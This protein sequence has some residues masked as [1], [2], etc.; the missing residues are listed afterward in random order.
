MDDLRRSAIPLRKV[1]VLE[2][3]DH[4]QRG[5]ALPV[6]RQ[7]AQLVALAVSDAGYIDPLAVVSGE[8]FQRKGAALFAQIVHDDPR[9]LALVI[10]VAAIGCDP[11]QR[12]GEVGIAEHL[13]RFGC[14][15][16]GEPGR[17]GIFEVEI[18]PFE[19]RFVSGQ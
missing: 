3:V 9:G 19:A 5:K 6:G 2:D 1:H 16:V 13:A 15:S 18:E 17:P 14:I 10:F 12:V 7:L 11:F 4:L 8:I